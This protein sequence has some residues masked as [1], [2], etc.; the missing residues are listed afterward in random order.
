MT[1]PE[2][3][4]VLENF[5]LNALTLDEMALFDQDNVGIGT[6]NKL[7]LF[8]IQ[9]GNWTAAEVG[10]VTVGELGQVGAQLTEAIRSAAVPLA[11]STSSKTGRGS[12]RKPRRRSG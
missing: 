7:R 10:A 2:K 6:L 9:H 3:A 1:I 5:D 11:S 12:T 4:L 8:L